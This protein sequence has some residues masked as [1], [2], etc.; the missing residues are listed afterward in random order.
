MVG[1]SSMDE[2]PNIHMVLP[3]DIEETWAWTDYSNIIS[4]HLSHK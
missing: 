4:K 1:V 2:S 3:N